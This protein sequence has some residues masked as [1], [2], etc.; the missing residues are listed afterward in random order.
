MSASH[1]SA[2][3]P[4]VS[5]ILSV[6]AAAGA[7]TVRSHGTVLFCKTGGKNTAPDPS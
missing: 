4:F 2:Q 1:V 6:D 3:D 5:I 7:L